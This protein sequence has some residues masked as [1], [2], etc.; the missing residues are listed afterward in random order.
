[1]CA[2]QFAHLRA[3][4]FAVLTHSLTVPEQVSG[5]GYF[6]HSSVG[7]L[8]FQSNLSNAKI[9]LY[10]RCTVQSTVSINKNLSEE[11]IMLYRVHVGKCMFLT[12]IRS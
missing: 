4:I 8:I 11:V 6:L 9:E 5:D 3:T 1:M 10:Y 7:K 2:L 12:N